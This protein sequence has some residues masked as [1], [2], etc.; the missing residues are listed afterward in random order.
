VT[1]FYIVVDIVALISQIAG[2]GLE[3]TT[4]AHVV[5]IGGK[6]MLG[7]LIFQLLA[8][9]FFLFLA[10]RSQRKLKWSAGSLSKDPNI[11]WRRT[12]LSL[13]SGFDRWC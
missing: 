2:S 9:A 12:L 10:A 8:L 11:R 13:R 6:V 3:A 7:G 4:D 5:E 1:R